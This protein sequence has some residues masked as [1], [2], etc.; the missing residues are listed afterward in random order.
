M[1]ITD[2]GDQLQLPEL[3]S[4]TCFPAWERSEASRERCIRSS[5]SAV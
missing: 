4:L 5:K 2:D 1:I 3:L